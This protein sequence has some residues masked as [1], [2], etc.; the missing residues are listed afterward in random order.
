MPDPNATLQN[1]SKTGQPEIPV[2]INPETYSVSYGAN[3]ASL[4]APGLLMPLLQF[5]R[6]ETRVLTVEL[7]LDSFDN[8][9][10]ANSG[11]ASGG[12]TAAVTG[13]AAG[14]AGVTAPP[15][16]V[17]D[18]LQAIRKFV[19]IDSDLHAPPVCRF[20]WGD[21]SFDGVMAT[22]TERY[23]LFGDNGK[24]L[25]ARLSITIKSYRSVEDQIQDMST[26]SPDRTRVRT[27][28][29]GETLAQLAEEAYGD[30]RLW[31]AIAEANGIDHPRFIAPGTALR[32]PALQGTA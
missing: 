31:R 13:A 23:T 19:V 8:R 17:W 16:T 6:G 2:Q 29:E 25:R 5:V 11:L 1:V 20:K 10:D 28:R 18:R 9:S 21:V 26:H 27:I 7:L 24:I 30:P 3:Y 12:A 22:L 15:R 4:N 32:I 14:A